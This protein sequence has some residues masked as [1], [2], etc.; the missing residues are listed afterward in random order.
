MESIGNRSG[1]LLPYRGLDLTDES[2]LFCGKILC[3]LGADII[4]VEG[5]NGDPA[6]NVGPH[7]GGT[8]DPEKSIS[9]IALN[10]GK[11]SILLDIESADGREELKELVATA[12]FFIESFP[13]GYL[14]RLGL[15]YETLGRINPRLIFTSLTPFGQSG[16]HRDFLGSDLVLW[17]MSGWMNQSGHR[18]R[19]P[20][21]LSVPQSY[22]H[23]GMHAALGTLLALY[24]RHSSGLGQ[25]VDVSNQEALLYLPLTTPLWWFYTRRKKSRNGNRTGFSPSVAALTVWPCRDGEVQFSIWGGVLGRLVARLVDWMAEEGWAG[26]LKDIDWGRLDV[27]GLSAQDVEKMEDVFSAFFREHTKKDLEENARKRRIPLAPV[28]TIEDLAKD[29]QLRA[30]DYWVELENDAIGKRLV[31]PGAPW[32]F[33]V[34]PCRGPHASAP[35]I[36]EHGAEIRAELAEGKPEPIRHHAIPSVGGAGT[37]ESALTGVKILD[38]SRQLAAPLGTACLA[39]FGAEVIKVESM[40]AIDNMRTTGPY[41]GNQAG[42]DRSYTAV[43]VNSSKLSIALNL[44][45]KKGREI[46]K[47]LVAWA[48]VVVENFGVGVMDRWG[49]GYQALRTIN[50]SLVMISSSSQGQTGPLAELIGFGVDLQA[51][52]GFTNI[53]GWPDR[54][55][56]PPH[57]AYTDVIAPYFLAIGIIA[58][59]DHRKRTGQGQYIDL[60]QHEAAATFLS[61]PVVHYSATGEVWTRQGNRSP[62]AAPHGVYPCQGDDRWCAITVLDEL[63]WESLC[64]A[65]GR[66][67][68]VEDSRFRTL[69]NRKLNEDELDA[70][71]AEW[72]IQFAPEELMALLQGAG[73][74]AGVVFD[75][76][77]LVDKDPHLREKGFYR[78]LDKPCFGECLHYGQSMKLS[79][80]PEKQRCGPLYGEHTQHV[81]MNVLNMS[82]DEFLEALHQGVLE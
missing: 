53:T 36:G 45:T 79:R 13:P 21:R 52:A 44:A 31:H 77:D 1:P 37:R 59:L 22:L 71:I 47:C 10:A 42:P 23:G 69:A 41:K 34:T 24:S 46:A 73:V 26:H 17:A 18:D 75:E 81:C 9:W 8:V 72:S 78:V 32:K 6:R 63:Q 25:H 7:Y 3:D 33:G 49:M 48:D 38:F 56:V 66:P 4:K 82:G 28:N 27:L 80:T 50:P 54:G 67:E 68:W 65:A 76:E 35:R 30:R 57:S 5:P 40:A 74:P 62:E 43:M 29:V 64:R 15:D 60:S 58:A 12:D 19:A 20:L 14:D 55:A 16:S 61:V 51:R 39:D 2:G 70:L 11:R